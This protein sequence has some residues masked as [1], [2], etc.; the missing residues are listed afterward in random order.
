MTALLIEKIPYAV[1]SGAM[2]ILTLYLSR[3]HGNF[4]PMEEFPLN[5]RLLV[6]GNAV[7]EYLRLIFFPVGILPYYMIPDPIPAA[8]AVTTAVVIFISVICIAAIRK[9]PCLSALWFM[10]LT[11][12]LPV[13]AFFQ[14][15]DQ[16]FAARFTY[17]PSV[18]P[19]IAAAAVI[20]VA[21]RKSAENGHQ[22]LQASL[23]VATI[24]LILFYGGMTLRLITVWDNAITLW[25]RIIDIEPNAIAYKQ[26][27]IVMTS[28]KRYNDAAADFA[29]AIELAPNVWQ[30]YLY[31]LMAFRGEA[32]RSAG[33]YNEAVQDLTA[34]INRYPHPAY[35][36]TRGLALQ[37][38]G[39]SQEA[40]QDFQ[41]AGDEQGPIRWYP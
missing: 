17:L 12:L 39:Q 2:A 6:S 21:Y 15:G 18:F 41:R 30:P 1:F 35:Y 13:L 5:Q 36:Y 31:N 33:R 28:A 14:N 38:L 32:L 8:Y 40:L 37:S 27:G 20:V 29:K 23:V 16:A 7:F 19:S 9:A 24:A 25:S 3:L 11:P 4:I 34:A 26:R 10:F 22:R